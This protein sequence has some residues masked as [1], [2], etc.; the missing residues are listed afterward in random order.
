MKKNV[1]K[2]VINALVLCFLLCDAVFSFAKRKGLMFSIAKRI[3]P[4]EKSVSDLDLEK[5]ERENALF[6]LNNYISDRGGVCA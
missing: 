1:W 5:Q 6:D 3:L 4:L 2:K